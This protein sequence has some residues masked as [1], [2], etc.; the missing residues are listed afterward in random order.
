MNKIAL[1]PNSQLQVC[2]QQQMATGNKTC[3]LTVR[4]M[5]ALS[6]RRLGY[7]SLSCQSHKFVKHPKAMS[8]T[9]VQNPG[10]NS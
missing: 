6:A 2:K 4:L 10:R 3:E 8:S 1:M 9:K 7:I 5:L